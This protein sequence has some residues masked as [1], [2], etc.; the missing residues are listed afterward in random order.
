MKKAI[1]RKL[2]AILLCLLASFSFVGSA[3]AQSTGLDAEVLFTLI[4]NHR[5][6]INLPPFQ[7]DQRLCTLA[8][9][10]APEVYNEIYVT[11]NMHAG[12]KNRDIPYWLNENIISYR[13]N[14]GAFNWWMHSPVHRSAI[15]G[16]FAYS[17]GACYGNSCSQLFSNF[18]P[19]YSSVSAK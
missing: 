10:R 9:S 18:V 3:F 11:H 8:Q 4:N 6:A 1:F 2:F 12:L 14:D 15:E 7:K 13:D 17:C 16:D 5:K 19:K